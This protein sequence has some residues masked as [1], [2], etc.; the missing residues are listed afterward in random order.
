M[1][2]WYVELIRN[3]LAREKTSWKSG[4][5]IGLIDPVN[6][7]LFMVGGGRQELRLNLAVRLRS[8]VAILGNMLA[9]EAV[10]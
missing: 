3:S 1:F 8:P 2:K 10:L 4:K 6:E 9:L 7:M 5:N